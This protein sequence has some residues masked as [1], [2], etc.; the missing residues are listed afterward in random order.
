MTAKLSVEHLTVG[1]GETDVLRDVSLEVESGALGAILG[2]SGCGKTTLLRA[3][4][5]LERPRSGSL[6]LGTQML[7]T[8]GINLAPEK[9]NIGWVPQDAALFPHLSVAEN[10]AFG[11][12]R[13]SRGVRKAARTQRVQELLELVGLSALRERMPAQ[14]SGGQAQR[15]ALARALANKPLLVLLDEPFA[16]LDPLLRADLRAEVKD[17]LR[18]QETTSLLVTHDQEEA[19]SLA[20]HIA[21]MR[22]GHI[23]QAGTPYEVYKTPVSLWCAEFMGET[24]VLEG[25]VRDDSVI[26]ELGALPLH[27][28]GSESPRDGDVVSVMLRPELLTIRSGSDYALGTVEY[29]GH[30]ALVHLSREGFSPIDVR[31]KASH[32]EALDNNVDV[33]VTGPALSYPRG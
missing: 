6:R 26:T 9:R 15:V 11:L 8:H 2:P 31:L 5:G 4:A 22:Q 20:D 25:K 33:D 13:S 32:L 23:E 10:I 24:N 14:L 28:M 18:R 29:A 1:Y 7:S 21:I 19:L 27:W 3:I 16:G 17:I 12:A 30:D